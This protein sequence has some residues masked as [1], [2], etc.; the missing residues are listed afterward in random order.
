MVIKTINQNTLFLEI[1][2]ETINVHWYPYLS[3][4][5]TFSDLAVR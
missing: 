5:L 4:T 3:P 1:H 2:T